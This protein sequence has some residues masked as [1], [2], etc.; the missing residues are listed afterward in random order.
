MRIVKIDPR[1]V[2]YLYFYN[3]HFLAKNREF[4]GIFTTK[5]KI[6]SP[7]RMLAIKKKI[8]IGSDL[9]TEL[10]YKPSDFRFDCFN[11][12]YSCL[13]LEI[14]EDRENTDID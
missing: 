6:C 5:Y 4:G 2:Y 1:E 3:L 7:L 12:L 14:L 11:F 13:G 8:A 10:D 9:T